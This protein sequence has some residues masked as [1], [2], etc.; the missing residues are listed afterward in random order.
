M[1]KP[2]A[3][4]AS[5]GVIRADDPAQFAAAFRRICTILENPDLTGDAARH[6]LVEEYVPGVEVALGATIWCEFPWRWV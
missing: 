1:L 2:L 5:R 3:L 6:I 4:S